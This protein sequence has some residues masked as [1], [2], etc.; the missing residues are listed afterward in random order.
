M[1]STANDSAKELDLG[2]VDV[3]VADA[4]HS[5]L[6]K[7]THVIFAGVIPPHPLFGRVSIKILSKKRSPEECLV[8]AA[9]ES[10]VLMNKLVEEISSSLQKT[11]GGSSNGIL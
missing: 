10:K 3:S 11:S 5:V 8:N 1:D 7:D 9:K 2:M 4:L 6:T